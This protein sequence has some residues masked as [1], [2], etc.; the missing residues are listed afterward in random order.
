MIRVQFPVRALRV[1]LE[2][3][4]DGL[5]SHVYG[6]ESRTRYSGLR[7]AGVSRQAKSVRKNGVVAQM[8]EHLPCKQKAAG[9]KPVG[10]ISPKYVDWKNK[11]RRMVR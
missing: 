8:E 1:A 11:K 4:H 6:F 9:S 10:S 3:F 2:R 5:I 7:F